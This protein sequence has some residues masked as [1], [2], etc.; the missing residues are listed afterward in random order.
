MARIETSVF[1]LSQLD[2]LSCGQTVVHRL[3]PRVKVL[4]TLFFTG[5]VVS[6][7]K[8]EIA[9]LLPFALYPAVLISLGNLPPG[10]LMKKVLW[11]APLAVLIGIFNPLLDPAILV[12]LG[13]FSLSGGW[14]SF[15][16]ILVKFLLTVTTALCLVATTGFN[17][18]CT[19]LDRMGVPRSFVI[20]LQFLYRYIHVLTDDAARMSRA[21]SLRSFNGRGMGMQVF[22]SLV[23]Q[24]LLRTLDRA[25]R[26]HAAMLCRG[27]DGEIR[28]LRPLNLRATDIGFLA[29]WCGL[30]VFLRLYNLP[31]WLGHLAAGTAL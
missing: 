3:D 29:G 15:G 18:V 6:F 27:F 28:L 17:A 5:I 30:F 25:R 22:A 20:Q 11:A 24:L 19:A 12:Q 9:P 26:I 31:R 16:A 10:H 1:D 23:G 14:I 4:T 2:L 13:P 21:R 7:P 8:Y